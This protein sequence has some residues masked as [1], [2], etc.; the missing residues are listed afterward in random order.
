MTVLYKYGLCT[1]GAKE[2]TQ[3][4]KKIPPPKNH[5]HKTTQRSSQSL[6]ATNTVTGFL[7]SSSFSSTLWERSNNFPL[8]SN[9]YKK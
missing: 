2:K 8:L 4:K 3:K 7:S 1:Y 6:E 9:L 5:P